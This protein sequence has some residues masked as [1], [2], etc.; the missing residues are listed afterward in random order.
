MFTRHK[1]IETTVK[2]EM[3]F[4]PSELGE[5]HNNYKEVGA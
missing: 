2:N 4:I 1:N 3:K 5:F